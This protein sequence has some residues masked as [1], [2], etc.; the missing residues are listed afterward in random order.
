MS[1]SEQNA[2]IRAKDVTGNSFLIYPITKAENVD[3]LDE[4]IDKT[5]PA[6]YIINATYD[7][8]TV[9]KNYD[10]IVAAYNAGSHLVLYHDSEK[11]DFVAGGPGEFVFEKI[12][13][14]SSNGVTVARAS[15]YGQDNYLY[16]AEYKKYNGSEIQAALESKADSDHNHDSSYDAL[17]AATAAETSAKTYADSIGTAKLTEAKT[18]TDTRL[19]AVTASSDDGT[20][21]TATVTGIDSLTSGVS[22]V[23]IPSVDSAST[24]PTLNVN[25]LGAKTIRRRLSNATKAT[26][27]GYASAWLSAGK[28]IRVTYDGTYWIADLPKPAAA[29]ISGTVSVANGGTGASSADTAIE[30]LGAVKKSG[31]T[32]TGALAATKFTA[33]ADSNPVIEFF[34]S[35]QHGGYITYHTGQRVLWFFQYGE[36][37]SI[38]EGYGLPQVNESLTESKWYNILTTK[39]APVYVTA[40]GT[41]NNW[42]YR[43]YSDGTVDLWY[44]KTISSMSASITAGYAYK[45]A[46]FTIDD[47]PFTVTNPVKEMH[48]IPSTNYVAWP[49]ENAQGTIELYRPMSGNVEGTLCVTVHGTYS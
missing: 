9:D 32:M 43:K 13:V 8:A 47:M 7:M 24:A 10:D 3:G 25:S 34:P 23:I 12:N 5:Q 20:A 42:T 35:G 1:V 14:G 27:V 45:T 38:G 6:D 40:T 44:R 28:S 37:L 26:V 15:I 4:L 33:T 22:F 49:L 2:L 18:Y 21:Y 17:G 41:G 19:A 30:N 46:T 29:D 36:G 16:R 39:N 11:F 48:F 31:D